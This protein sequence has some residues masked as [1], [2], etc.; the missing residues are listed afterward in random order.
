MSLDYCTV[1]RLIVDTNR[2]LNSTTLLSEFVSSLSVR[3]KNDI[4][5][6]YYTPHWKKVSSRVLKSSKAFDALTVHIAV[7]S[8]TDSLNGK[9]RPMQLALLYD[10]ASKLEKK[11]VRFWI[12]ELK[13]DFPDFLIARNKPYRGDGEGLTSY[14]RN[15]ID[16][17][18]YIGIEL[19]INQKTLL[20]LKSKERKIFSHRIGASLKRALLKIN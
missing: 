15:L 13:I 8:M 20:S 16:V 17:N 18:N 3:E 7:H 6:K 19:E 10:P 9:S 4:I 2:F 12:D 1:S 14:F 11:L 5:K